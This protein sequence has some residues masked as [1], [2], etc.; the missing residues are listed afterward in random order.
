MSTV[1]SMDP[2]NTDKMEDSSKN[3]TSD[4]VDKIKPQ[5]EIK[6]DL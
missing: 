5:P 3:K 4:V 2:K 6:I 1:I